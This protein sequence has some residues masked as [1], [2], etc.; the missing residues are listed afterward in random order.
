VVHSSDKRQ[1]VGRYQESVMRLV[2]K[3]RSTTYLHLDGPQ[4]YSFISLD[5]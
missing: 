4:S 2:D 3:V 1:A 5:D